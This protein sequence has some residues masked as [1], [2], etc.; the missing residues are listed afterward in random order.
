MAPTIRTMRE[1]QANNN[2]LCATMKESQIP[3]LEKSGEGGGGGLVAEEDDL[4]I[5][6][7]KP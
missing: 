5:N 7:E 4:Q 6:A 1:S 2:I 3:R